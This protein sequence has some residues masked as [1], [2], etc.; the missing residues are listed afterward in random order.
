[1]LHP[2][3]LVLIPFAF[4]LS[5]CA[6]T[7]APAADA[8]TAIAPQVIE[9]VGVGRGATFVVCTDDSC[10]RRTPKTLAAAA[11]APAAP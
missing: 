4:A 1:M 5:A 10:P 6:H 8:H 7:E 11:D 9:Q 3:F 2:V